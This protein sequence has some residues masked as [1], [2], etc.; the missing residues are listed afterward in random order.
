MH[1]YFTCDECKGIHSVG[2]AGWYPV[3][4]VGD[5]RCFKVVVLTAHPC[6]INWIKFESLE[7]AEL[8]INL[9]H[10]LHFEP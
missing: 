4:G 8:S 5:L 1:S 3:K 10:T 9:H 2:L 7:T 6:S